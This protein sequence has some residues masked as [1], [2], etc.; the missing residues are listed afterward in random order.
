V[1]DGRGGLA[2]G[3]RRRRTGEAALALGARR[4]RRGKADWLQAA[5]WLLRRESGPQVVQ[6]DGAAGRCWTWQEAMEGGQSAVGIDG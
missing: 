6:G 2:P 5:Q 3:V 4:F 1:A